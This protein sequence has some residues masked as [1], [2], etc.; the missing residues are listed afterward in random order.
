MTLAQTF[1]WEYCEIFKTTYFEKHLANDCFWNLMKV[2]FDSWNRHI[3]LNLLW[4]TYFMCILLSDCTN[5]VVIRLTNKRAQ[6]AGSINNLVWH[7]KKMRASVREKRTSSWS[8]PC[9][10][11]EGYSLWEINCS[12][13][14]Y[15]DVSNKVLWFSWRNYLVVE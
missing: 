14:A 4:K 11:D 5:T 7:S 15:K 12:F 2:F 6:I 10:L 9:K 3:I 8:W 13:W 1:S